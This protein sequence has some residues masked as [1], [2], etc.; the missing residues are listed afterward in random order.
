MGGTDHKGGFVN[1][2]GVWGEDIGEPPD[3]GG[4]YRI[5]GYEGRAN[6]TLRVGGVY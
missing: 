4:D 1:G 2:G 5:R 6:G 3:H